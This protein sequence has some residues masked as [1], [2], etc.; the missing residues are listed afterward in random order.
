MRYY[1]LFLN[2][3][4][5]TCLVVG[6]GKVGARKARG[7]LSAGA[8]VVVVSPQMD[9]SL[10]VLRPHERLRL[11]RR[12]YRP[13]DME[14]VFLV[15]AATDDKAQNRRIQKDAGGRQ[16]L[17]NIADRP[18]LCDF[19]LPAV[20]RQGDLALAITTAGK[21]PALAK[22]LRRQFADQLGPEY[23]RLT[24]LLGAIRRRLLSEGHDPEGHQQV[25]NTLLDGDLLGLL[26]TDRKDEIDALLAATLGPGYRLENLMPAIEPETPE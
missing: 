1:P 6:G 11:E 4:N 5:R 21:S 3:N 17:C 9:A 22:R 23:A 20:V 18:E 25:F 19:I 10:E 16:T 15:F 24:E 13:Q 8:R 26:R 2:L 14:G 7:L 12:A